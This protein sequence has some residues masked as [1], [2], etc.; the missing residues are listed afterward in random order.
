M[1]GCRDTDS[2]FCCR[3][4]GVGANI[5][6]PQIYGTICRGALWASAGHI[7]I[8]GLPKAAPTPFFCRGEGGAANGCSSQQIPTPNMNKL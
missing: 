5:I 7:I 4:S 3:T 1:K 6:R 8:C 2:L